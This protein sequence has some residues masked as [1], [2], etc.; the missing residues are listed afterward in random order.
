MPS[1]AEEAPTLPLPVVEKE[2]GPPSWGQL[3][4]ILHPPDPLLSRPEVVLERND[5]L[6]SLGAVIPVLA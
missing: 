3:W 5:Q 2:R 6:P 1:I 4:D